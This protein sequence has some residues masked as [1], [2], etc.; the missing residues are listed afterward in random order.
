MANIGNNDNATASHT[1]EVE[2]DSEK[3]WSEFLR[4]SLSLALHLIMILAEIFAMVLFLISG[5]AWMCVIMLVPFT[6]SGVLCFLAA[7]DLETPLLGNVGLPLSRRSCLVQL[8]LGIPF[9][10][11]QG[12]IVVLEIEEFLQRRQ[13]CRMSNAYNRA[14]SRDKFHPKAVNGAFEGL[15]A[16][17][18]VLFGFWTLGFSDV[19]N[20]PHE[21]DHNVVKNIL[22]TCLIVC[23]FSTGLCLLQLDFAVS[24]TTYKRMRSSVKYEVCHF[25]FRTL[26][27]A[28]RCSLIIGF[29]VLTLERF[30]DWWWM[31][32]FLDFLCCLFL[33]D[34]YGGCERTMLVHI[35]CATPCVFA[36][37]F[38]FVD[39]P[40]K[41]RAARKLS[42]A[43]SYRS[44][45]EI[46]V[47]PVLYVV[48]IPEVMG[49]LHRFWTN[50]VFS[51]VMACLCHPLYWGMFLI[52]NHNPWSS[53]DD[54]KK[55]IFEACED[56]DTDAVMALTTK[57]TQV[58]DLNSFDIDGYT[59]LMLVVARCSSNMDGFTEAFIISLLVEEGARVDLEI[60]RDRRPIRKWLQ[61][62]MRLRWTA[63][64]LAA[65]NG[66]LTVVDALVTT[67]P[68]FEESEC[69]ETS[70]RSNI[71]RSDETSFRSNMQQY[72]IDKQGETPLHI[73]AGRGH[74]EVVRVLLEAFPHWA[75]VKNLRRETPLDLAIRKA[76]NVEVQNILRN[77]MESGSGPLLPPTATTSLRSGRSV[78]AA[79]SSP[80][81]RLP[82]V[83]SFLDTKPT[84]APG[85]S[86]FVASCGGGILGK[87]F[88]VDR[89]T[90]PTIDEGTILE[91][92][93]TEDGAPQQTVPDEVKIPQLQDLEQIGENGEPVLGALQFSQFDVDGQVPGVRALIHLS[94]ESVLGQGA[95][96][97]VWRAR[98][99]TQPGVKFAVK[100]IYVNR[101]SA[102]RSAQREF[103]MG[104][105][106][107][108][109]PH[110]CIVNCF[111][112]FMPSEGFF[113][114]IMELCPCG[115]LKKYMQDAR[116][117]SDG[118]GKPYEPPES[119][120]QWIGGVF[121]GLEHLHVK[122]NSLIR[123]L[124][125]DNVVVNEK[126]LAKLTDFG[127]GRFGAESTGEWSFNVPP[128]SPG[129]IAPEALLQQSY[130]WKVDLYSFGV[131]IWVLLTGG[132]KYDPSPR[133]PMGKKKDND[134]TGNQNDW[135]LLQRCLQD[136]EKE[137]APR[138][139]SP[140]LDLVK[141]LVQRR[142]ADRPAHAEIRQDLFMQELN[143]PES[144][145]PK[146]VLKA[147]LESSI[148]GS[149]ASS[150]SAPAHATNS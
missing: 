37:V 54:A 99:R 65:W 141:M 130:D 111:G 124:K 108:F 69:D 35:I 73:A 58:I 34:V 83:E 137:K 29:M 106:I 136:P 96:G 67:Q 87:V 36:N 97:R 7:W 62:P 140:A 98:D 8:F 5:N 123:D 64:H 2:G 100:N 60:F 47:L 45:V 50:H 104:I 61:R 48:F 150:S 122:M 102:Q 30:R 88:L 18:V 101:P 109:K 142:P 148:H 90:L 143:L 129:Y 117:A 26:E 51:V 145:C 44:V 57:S 43:L 127:F 14:Q 146:E 68:P 39:S 89:T 70:F 11:L 116:T 33:V 113:M 135:K 46:V 75:N 91:D 52:I 10:L 31:P 53:G 42:K 125:P 71:Q 72:Y 77:A 79:N 147:W 20:F 25:I 110:P 149:Q 21:W 19:V 92:P 85:L 118:S 22:M 84:K 9:G 81:V 15:I 3:R 78:R 55:D 94:E 134:Y 63:L 121:L 59:P 120:N 12:V 13:G 107:R 138:L 119:S 41:K 126:G 40:Y 56:A 80:W 66:C 128:G 4:V 6:V 17:A 1:P 144:C 38:R 74:V 82:V 23:F 95:F 86:S 133:P 93:T 105:Q 131:L 27:V 76:A 112:S 32:V 132:V 16:S 28:S 49:E 139:E 114:M 115:D 24:S 103:E